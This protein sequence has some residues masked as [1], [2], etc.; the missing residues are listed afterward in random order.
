VITTWLVVTSPVDDGALA[1][2]A[3]SL[4]GAVTASAPA[5]AP[6]GAPSGFASVSFTTAEGAGARRAHNRFTL[7]AGKWLATQ[8]ASCA[9]QHDGGQWRHAG[10]G[11]GA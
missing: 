5:A 4:G 6:P 8:G 2:F 11:S 10:P 3:L 9:W 7:E 1:N